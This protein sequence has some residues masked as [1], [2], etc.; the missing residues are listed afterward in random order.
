MN[1]LT[2]RRIWWVFTFGVLWLCKAAMWV[3]AIGLLLLAVTCLGITA[4][5]AW[6]QAW[7]EILAA[8]APVGIFSLII[9]GICLIGVTGWES[10]RERNGPHP[11]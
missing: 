2:L 3:A 7:L 8:P 11:A 6:N 5:L 9:G 10:V 1:K 4:Y